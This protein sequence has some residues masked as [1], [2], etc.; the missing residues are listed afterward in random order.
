MALIQTPPAGSTEQS[1][2]PTQ[3][4][5]SQ[6]EAAVP[7][8]PP[9]TRTPPSPPQ[10]PNMSTPDLDPHP[11]TLVIFHTITR[12]DAANGERT[13]PRFTDEQT[14]ELL[15]GRNEPEPKSKPKPKWMKV[16]I[17]AE[18]YETSGI[19]MLIDED[20]RDYS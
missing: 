16:M 13:G 6:G 5:P 1:V 15:E 4:S 7:S 20:G 19:E 3:S 18:T 8:P 12:T 11:G 10:P 17:R 14:L 9:P 2:L